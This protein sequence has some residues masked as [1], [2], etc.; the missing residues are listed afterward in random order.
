MPYRI[1]KRGSHYQVVN[2][3]TGKVHAKHTTKRRAEAQVRLLRDKER[4]G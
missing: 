2:A 3:T 4:T 1:L